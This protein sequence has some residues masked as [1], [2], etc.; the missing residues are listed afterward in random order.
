MSDRNQPSS[1]QRISHVLGTLNRYKVLL[2][3]PAA[4]GF[5]LSVVYVLLLRPQTWSARQSIIVRD[6]LLGQSYKPGRFDSMESM[7]SA[8]ET[9]LEL[10]RNPQVIRGALTQ[11]GPVKSRFLG[12][13]DSWPDDETIEDVQGSINISAPN[14]EEFGTTETIVL[15]TKAST[16]ERSGQF[17]ELL[18]AEIISKADEVRSLRLQSMVQELSHSHLA[19]AA[20]LKESQDKLREMDLELGADV[21]AMLN[22]SGSEPS[23]SMIKRDMSQLKIEK[24]NTETQLESLNSVLDQLIL[25]SSNP[26]KSVSI[27]GELIRYQPALEGLKNELIK[28]QRKFAEMVSKYN[29]PHPSLLAAKTEFESMKNQMFLELEGSIAGLEKEKESTESR[30][31]RLKAD[32]LALDGRLKNLGSKRAERVALEAELKQRTE[33]A[34]KSQSDLGEIQG[35]AISGGGELLTRVDQPQVS[36]RPDGPGEKIVVI[37]GMLG[38]F[39]LGLGVILLVAPPAESDDEKVVQGSDGARVDGQSNDMFDRKMFEG[40]VTR[41]ATAA[42]AATAAT[43]AARRGDSLPP[44]TDRAATAPV[45]TNQP[46]S[47]L[48]LGARQ[49]ERIKPR[50]AAFE[51][52]SIDSVGTSAIELGVASAQLPPSR[53]SQSS[54]VQCNAFQ[55]E[56]ELTSM[57]KPTPSADTNNRS[58]KDAVPG[59]PSVSDLLDAASAMNR[60]APIASQPLSVARP[61]PVPQQSPVPQ[62]MFASAASNPASEPPMSNPIR[63]S[64]AKILSAAE[65]E[66]RAQAALRAIEPR[67]SGSTGSISQPVNPVDVNSGNAHEQSAGRMAPAAPL[68]NDGL[69]GSSTRRNPSARPVSLAKSLDSN[70]ATFAPNQ[71][72]ASS[73]MNIKAEIV[74]QMKAA[75]SVT[76]TRS[77]NTEPTSENLFLQ[78]SDSQWAAMDQE[79]KTD[80]N[81]ELDSNSSVPDRVKKLSES[82]AKF[83]K[84]KMR[85]EDDGPQG[86]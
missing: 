51:T 24:R 72:E 50:P 76:I 13:S 81:A 8:Q 36:T 60:P 59:T 22:L 35:L 70:A 2:I 48:E 85:Q 17:I 5:L 71:P 4:L 15:S 26:E 45:T 27:S 16:R 80:R 56:S 7:K 69:D 55:A 37:A 65:M 63:S 67:P 1:N 44:T 10:A 74:K 82:I 39:M 68:R 9:I 49:G 52:Q 46:Q 29:L 41:A 86:S 28:T 57:K 38:G 43:H 19:A 83:A 21:G 32:L 33:F 61:A 54:P 31:A 62:Q 40:V 34:S 75:A 79:S 58:S 11:L 25:A 77:G 64:A 30:L 84:Q 73:A 53:S 23:D 47:E 42:A 18:L 14:G 3:A 6:D 78:G 12:N 66:L 20:A